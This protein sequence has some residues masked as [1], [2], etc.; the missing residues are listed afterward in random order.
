MDVSISFTYPDGIDD[1]ME[2]LEQMRPV[3]QS[4]VPEPTQT[5]PAASTQDA[6]VVR[7]HRQMDPNQSRRFLEA[8]TSDPLTFEELSARMPKPDGSTHSNASMRAIYR[9]IR[10]QEITLTNRSVIKGAVVQWNFD[11]YDEEGAG[12]YYL[13]PDALEALDAQLGR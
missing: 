10:R 13:E 12:R 3:L 5:A 9:N 8:L 11:K 2:R 7:M 4:S 1:A 6:D